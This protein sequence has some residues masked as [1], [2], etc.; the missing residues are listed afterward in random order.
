MHV[1]RVLLAARQDSDNLPQPLV[2]H[3]GD[4][5]AAVQAPVRPMHTGATAVGLLRCGDG[6]QNIVF[7]DAALRGAL[8]GVLAQLYRGAEVQPSQGAPAARL[9]AAHPRAWAAATANCCQRRRIRGSAAPPETNRIFLST[10]LLLDRVT[11]RPLVG[12]V[13]CR[14]SLL[15]KCCLNGCCGSTLA[16]RPWSRSIGSRCG[17]G[18]TAAS[19]I[20]S[21][22]RSGLREGGRVD[23][24]SARPDRDGQGRLRALPHRH[25]PAV[26]GEVQRHL[27]NLQ[28]TDRHG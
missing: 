6:Q 2:H 20:M 14:S 24:W 9:A 17:Q 28:A 5:S 10:L 22:C 13:T 15:E 21:R 7:A 18:R 11:V 26:A 4:I 1:V 8:E 16:D 25:R 23:C 19:R 12:T 27:R 3:N